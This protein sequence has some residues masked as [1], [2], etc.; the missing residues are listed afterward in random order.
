MKL[1]SDLR[2]LPEPF[3]EHI[4]GPVRWFAQPKKETVLKG[5]I[6]YALGVPIVVIILFYMTDIL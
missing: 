6:A 1:A 2:P 3:R 4:A 5:I